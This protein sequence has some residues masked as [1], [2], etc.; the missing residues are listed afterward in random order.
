VLAARSFVLAPDRKVSVE[1]GHQR[2]NPGYLSVDGGE[3]CQ[4]CPG[5]IICVSKSDKKVRFVDIPERSFYN[6]VF[7]KLGEK[8]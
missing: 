2:T 6:K 7:E 5:D 4:V 1:F 3:S 8:Y